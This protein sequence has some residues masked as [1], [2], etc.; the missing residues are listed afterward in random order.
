[1]VDARSIIEGIARFVPKVQKP[2]RKVGFGER[3]LWTA[4]ILTIFLIMGQVPLYGIP[5]GDP[6]FQQTI[7][8]IIFAAKQGTLLEL[9]IGPIVT[10]GLIMQILVGTRL[11]KLDM[12]D[13]RDRA[14]FTSAQKVLTVL[15]TAIQAAGSALAYRFIGTP[16]T[17]III[18]IQ[19]FAA[20]IMLM[21]MDEL[22][23]KGWGIGSG[24]SLFIAAGV[25]QH[26][27]WFCFSPLPLRED[28]SPLGIFIAL[29][30]Y[31]MSGKDMWSL[32]IGSP[33]APWLPTLTGF[34]V[35]VVVFVIIVYM[36]S[37]RVE[38]PIVY[39]KYGGF[40]AKTP[41]KLLYVS[42]IPVIFFGV[43]A[44]NVHML[45][46][47]T[48]NPFIMGV[49]AVFTPPQSLIGVIQN[50]FHALGY[51]LLLCS[52]CA[53]LALAWV[54]A[55]G[56][57]AKRQAEQIVRS[58]LQIPGFRSAPSVIEQYLAKYIQ[59][60]TWVSGVIVAL[61]AAIGDVFGVLGG[62]IGIL[63]LVGILYQYYQMLIRE[64][65]LEMY[66]M[67]RQFLGAE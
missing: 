5:R 21:L 36:E 60:L 40:K 55:S 65:A 15:V 57:S 16:L 48:G 32:F 35:M 46:Q 30:S 14:L 49:N 38:V 52:T 61:I 56:M 41:L 6:S 18:F 51:V 42:N 64:R 67:L 47:L 44:A 17:P 22:I 34:I 58:G 33:E 11:I 7:F 39:S 26:I 10:A 23:S 9:G 50:P 29:I 19:L 20:T 13:P 66:P 37:M 31:A 27:F 12:T 53:L 2:I 8:N 1:M 62:G 25:A 63:L 45:A 3:I 24:V 59:T 4:L 54:E 43:I 28:G